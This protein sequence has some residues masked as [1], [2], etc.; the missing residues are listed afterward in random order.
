MWHNE[1]GIVAGLRERIM[2]V[3]F[4]WENTVGRYFSIYQRIGGRVEVLK[5]EERPAT[6]STF[7]STS[8]GKAEVVLPIKVSTKAETNKPLAKK[9]GRAKK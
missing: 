9:K 6:A 7:V 4:S 5:Q 2:A 1:P 3:D 8:A